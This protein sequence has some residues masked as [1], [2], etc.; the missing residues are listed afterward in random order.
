MHLIKNVKFDEKNIF[1]NKDINVSQNFE[2]S[3]NESKMKKFWN[4]EDDFLLNVHSR[5]NWFNKSKKI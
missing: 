3:N 4:F 5:R 2:N 1:Y